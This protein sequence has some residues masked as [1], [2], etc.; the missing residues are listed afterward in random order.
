[1][2]AASKAKLA[3]AFLAVVVM[4]SLPATASATLA[5]DTN[6]FV[7]E[8]WVSPNEDGS[9]AKPIGSGLVI[10]VS[11][12]GEYVAYTH[13]EGFGGRV[14]TLYEV[15]TGERRTVFPKMKED[16]TFAWSPD[17]TMLAAVQGRRG[18]KTLYVAGVDGG[19]TRIA[20]GHFDGV[21]FSPDSTEIVFA[22]AASSVEASFK[23]PRSNL[24]RAPVDGGPTT[25]LTHDDLSSSPLWGPRNRI[26]FVRQV[27]LKRQSRRGSKND[28]FLMD[29][30]GRRVKR[31][32]NTKVDGNS[33]GLFPA[34]WSP[35]GDLLLANFRGFY[36]NFAVAVDTLHGGESVLT[37]RNEKQSFAA[38]AI[39]ADGRT[40]LGHIG[41]LEFGLAYRTIAAAPITGGT[42]IPLK[43]GAYS[44]SWGGLARPT[45]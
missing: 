1:M 29:P 5:F 9:D 41:G 37:P 21:S 20:S 17:S 39:A 2:S 31:L 27:D 36:E 18:K 25:A 22:L 34:V 23:V 32:T 30:D 24:V 45:A 15:S 8:V 43:S 10:G 33:N 4:L 6:P 16:S 13:G 28:L 26:A 12:N 44:P 19:K 42:P 40:V 7:P 35:E 14:L 11:P 3:A 38:D